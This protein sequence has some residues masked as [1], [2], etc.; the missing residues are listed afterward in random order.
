M[1]MPSYAKKQQGAALIV[2][3]LMLILLTML[4]VTS[5]TSAILDEKMASNR[6]DS[7]RAF[8]S[9]DSAARYAQ[10][11]VQNAVYGVDDFI[12]NVGAGKGELYDLRDAGSVVGNKLA[13]DWRDIRS[14]ANWPWGDSNRRSEMPDH[15]VAANPMALA[16]RPQFVVGMQN[17]SPRK[18]SEGYECIPYNI[19]GAGAGANASSRSLVEMKVITKSSCFRSQVK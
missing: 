19:I 7:K 10:A 13:A 12:G 5:M 6:E 11:Q 3:L 16:V 9:A 15:I 2:G 14:A 4:G 18:G 17:A 8:L 1:M